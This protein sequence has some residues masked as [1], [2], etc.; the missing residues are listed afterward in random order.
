MRGIEEVN[1]LRNAAARSRSSWRSRRRSTGSVKRSAGFFLKQPP[2]NRNLPRFASA[3]PRAVMHGQEFFWPLWVVDPRPFV[4]EQLHLA[5]WFEE[6]GIGH[7]VAIRS[8]ETLVDADCKLSVG[9]QLRLLMLCLSAHLATTWRRIE[10][11]DGGQLRLPVSRA[12]RPKGSAGR[13]ACSL[14]PAA[15]RSECARLRF[16]E[17]PTACYVKLSSFRSAAPRLA[18]S[19]SPT[20]IALRC[21]RLCS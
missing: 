2:E 13:A 5:D 10:A 19:P 3:L 4:R 8:I 12:A 14:M 18:G 1:R 6:A 11:R 15:S 7:F 21:Q 20:P 17:Q 9:P 16:R